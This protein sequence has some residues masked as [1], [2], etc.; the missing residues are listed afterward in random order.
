MGNFVVI[1]IVIILRGYMLV[2]FVVLS[3][4]PTMTRENAIG[5]F[6]SDYLSYRLSSGIVVCF[7]GRV[8]S[9]NIDCAV[10]CRIR[11]AKMQSKMLVVIL[12]HE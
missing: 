3:T 9:S 8:G 7:N 11:L 5:S 12:W 10:V 2:D 4:L 1:V 6:Q